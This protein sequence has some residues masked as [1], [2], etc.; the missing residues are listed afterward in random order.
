MNNEEKI[1]LFSSNGYGDVD[2]GNDNSSSE[3]S[4]SF[5]VPFYGTVTSSQFG[6]PLRPIPV[7]ERITYSWNSINVFAD[8]ATAESRNF[9]LC[10]CSNGEYENLQK[11]HLV[12]NVNGVARPGE[13]LAILGSSGAGKT[14]L[15]NALTFRSSKNIS[16]TGTRCVNG[17]PVHS[18]ALTSIS[19]YVQQADMFIGTLTVREHLTFQA[20]VRMDRHLKYDQRIARVEEVISEMSLNK[21]EN[22]CIGVPGR[23]KGLSGG[24]QKRLSFA[25]E[26]LTNPSLMFCD[27]PTSGLDSFMALNVVQILKQMAH[28][29]KTVICTIHQPSS[30]L[31]AMFDK[32]LLMAEGRIAFLGTPEEADIFFRELDAP[33]PKNYNPADYFIQL[34]AIVPD[35]EESCRHAVNMI[36]DKYERS[37]TGMEVTLE[38]STKVGDF[39]K[40][41]ETELW[42]NGTSNGRKSP[43][44]ASWCAQFRA[45]LWRSWLSILKEPL[46]VRV[47]LLQTILVSLILGSIYYG[48]VVNQDGVMNING[49]LFIFLTNLTFQNVFAVINVFSAELPLF[50]REH[51]N[52]MYRT[53][54]YFLGKTIAEIP[55]FVF[56]PLVFISIC[57]FLIGLNSEM[58]RFFV[59]CGIVVLVANAA[60]S[61]GYL[62]S[63]LSSSVSMALS[64]GPPLIMPFLLFGG[65]FLN[66]D[67]IPIYF[68]WLS[69]FSWFKYGNE[70]LLIN[71]WQNM[72]D[73]QCD[74]NSRN[75]PR[76]GHVVLEMYNFKEDDFF[77]DIYAM[78]GLILFFRLAAFFVLLRRT[79]KDQ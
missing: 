71:Q 72:T 15:L 40:N 66:I 62:I 34:L 30:E 5:R 36:C 37:L 63:C 1:P 59:A 4:G 57:Y 21:C 26:M 65:F 53:D 67:S 22:T 54:V 46:L 18:T 39:L 8:T 49:V 69:Y 24:E 42:L 73:I 10:C 76:N 77:L 7:E 61:F 20:L 12:K 78:V 31:Y 52:G 48:Q 17:N 27:E 50:L 51:K 33:C 45:V 19:A 29:G 16:V 70:A 35:N 55:F 13:L 11:K 38:S 3:S 60:T 74:E 25:S 6:I 32:L 64:I 23:L 9:C 47:R 43:Y 56:L 58:P 14:T 44:K 28:T 68:E 75:C 2:Q 79:Y 41:T